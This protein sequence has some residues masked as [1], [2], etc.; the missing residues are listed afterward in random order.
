[1]PCN[2]L[3]RFGG[4][5]SELRPEAGEVKSGVLEVVSSSQMSTARQRVFAR[6]Y[7]TCSEH[8]AVLFPIRGLTS[9][10]KPLASLNLKSC[11][12]E[13][14]DETGREFRVIPRPSEAL[15]LTFSVPESG[16]EKDSVHSWIAAFS[17]VERNER[18]LFVSKTR[19]TLPVLMENEEE[20]ENLS[21]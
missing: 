18:K 2:P 4:V 6:I 3:L 16:A 19:K 11:S 9:A 13:P 14:S 8:F 21:A 15:S 12:V 5:L 1:M 7:K 10:C 20:E 17:V